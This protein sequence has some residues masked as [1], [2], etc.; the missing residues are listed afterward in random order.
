M[1]PRPRQNYPANY[2][3]ALLKV[4]ES[5]E[6]PGTGPSGNGISPNFRSQDEWIHLIKTDSCESSDQLG[7]EYTR[8]I[9]PLFANS[10]NSGES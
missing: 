2:W 7:N 5:N 6:F 10:P 3:Y 1:E 9:P 4:P 8:M